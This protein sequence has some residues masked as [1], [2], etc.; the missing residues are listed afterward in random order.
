MSDHLRGEKG[1]S[2]VEFALVLP[3]VALVAIGLVQVGLS[4]RNQLAVELAAR[5]GARAA[6][7]AADS[8]GAAHDAAT[9]STRLPIEVATS[10]DGTTVS[11]TVTYTDDIAIP[12]LGSI[13]G[14][15]THT[16]TASMTLEPP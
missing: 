7:V 6:S 12:L 4:V 14:P 2:T 10:A 5:E 16:A 1:Q 13:L 9:T 15:V 3:V 8:S 11:V